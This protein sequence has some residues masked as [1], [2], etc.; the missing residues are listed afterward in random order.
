MK[1][2]E[3]KKDIKSGAEEKNKERKAKMKQRNIF[4]KVVAKMWL[5]LRTRWKMLN[6]EPLMFLLQ[7]MV[8][9]NL[10]TVIWLC[11]VNSNYVTYDME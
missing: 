10:L 4:R 5:I 9:Y 6:Y 11:L 2:K 7:I 8:H 1:E 3:T